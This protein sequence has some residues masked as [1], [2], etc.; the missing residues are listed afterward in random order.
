MKRVTCLFVSLLCAAAGVLSAQEGNGGIPKEVFYL[1]PDMAQG[2]VNFVGRAP[3]TGRF[4]ICAIDNSIRYNDKDGTE[5]MVEID[6]DMTSVVIG[7]VTFVPVDGMFYRLYPITGDVSVAV[8]REVLL[9]TDSKTAGYGMESQTTAVSTIMGM[10][11]DSKLYL[12]EDS[13]DIPYRMKETAFLYRGDTVLSLAKRSFQRCFPGARDAID[14][15]F[16]KNKKMDGTKVEEIIS[17]CREW[18]A[19]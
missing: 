12:F 14:E 13:K 9:M 17:L 4:N 15:W 1:M 7:G 16:S 5:L 10:N 2:S 8:R 6:G 18:G 3:A 11:G 19:K